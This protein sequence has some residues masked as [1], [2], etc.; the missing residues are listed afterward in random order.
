MLSEVLNVVTDAAGPE[1]AEVGKVLPYLPGIHADKICQFAAG[2][3]AESL[4]GH[5]G[6]PPQVNRQATDCLIWYLAVSHN[7]YYAQLVLVFTFTK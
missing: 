7:I 6:Q 1:V 4:P 2:D 5:K 3:V